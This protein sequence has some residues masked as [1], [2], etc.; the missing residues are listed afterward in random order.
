LSGAR[1]VRALAGAAV[2]L[3]VLS[4]L[5]VSSKLNG[6]LLCFAIALWVPLAWWQAPSSSRSSF[7]RG[8]LL[9]LAIAALCCVLLFFALNPVLWSDPVGGV[10]DVLARWDKLMRFF[11][12]ELGPAGGVEV[13]HST[14]ER[15]SLFVR[16]TLARDEPLNALTGLPLGSVA[17]VAGAWV[18]VRRA[19]TGE[20]DQA[21]AVLVFC[22]VFLAGTALWLPLDWERFYLTALPCIVLLEAALVAVLASAIERRARAQRS[23][24]ASR[25]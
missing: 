20:R 6:A 22:A 4:G 24:P 5:A 7:A 21:L 17:I 9:A 3:G 8:P 10:S 1:G 25:T 23:A 14:S 12:E 16:K 11:T 18:L 19:L 13:P 2:A 15:V